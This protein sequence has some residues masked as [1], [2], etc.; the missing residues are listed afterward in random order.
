[1]SHNCEGCIEK[2]KS[3][4]YANEHNHLQPLKHQTNFN[5]TLISCINTPH[6]EELLQ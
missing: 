3:V 2:K 4:H 1:M 6:S 5:Y